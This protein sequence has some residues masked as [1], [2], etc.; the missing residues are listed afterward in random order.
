MHKI[1][2]D[3]QEKTESIAIVE[4]GRL[5]EFY[6]EDER[7]EKLAGNIYRARV[8]NVLKG[9]EAAF[10][11]IG[12]GKQAFLYVKDALPRKE[13]KDGPKVSID[14]LV[15]SGEEIIVQVIK[16]P[17]GDKGAK[18]TSNITIPGRYLV[19]LPFDEE[20][21][22]SRKIQD[23]KEISRL[24]HIGKNIMKDNM[25]LIF[26]TAALGVDKSILEAE[27]K[28]L[29]NIY[30]EIEIQRNFLP[31]PKLLYKDLGLIFKLVQDR[32][33]RK[34]Y[35]IIVNCKDTYKNL[36]QFGQYLDYSLK[37]RIKLDKN[38]SIDYNQTIQEGLTE[39]LKRRVRL[40]SGGHIV[41][42]ET[43]ALTAIDVNTGKF[44]GN[45][46]LEETVFK[47]N[48]EA[49]EEI[50][51][52]IRLRNLG[53]IIIIDFIDM[54]RQKYINKLLNKLENS[55]SNHENRANILGMTKLGLVE[56]TRK[57]LGPSLKERLTKPCSS[58]EGQGRIR[59]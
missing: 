32:L 4:D 19:L 36:L 21:N 33:D 50:A 37:D 55:F 15:K 48:M 9:M 46:S 27:Y 58:C 56:V 42:D 44:V 23:E 54:K 45:I 6:V 18:I 53:G 40:A 13:L 28:S 7:Q 52:Q 17:V 25:G 2:I 34:D 26:R 57:R 59:N 51:R 41:I 38:F 10:V 3:S 43:E 11:N 49:A 22:I 30:K 35:E 14:E 31:T 5:V 24:R 8:E 20:I 1:F 16:D 12:E 47:T 39:A 29:I